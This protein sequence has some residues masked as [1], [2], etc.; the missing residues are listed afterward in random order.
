[1][2]KKLQA[3]YW[4]TP[5]NLKLLLKNQMV[6]PITIPIVIPG[7]KSAL[8]NL[9]AFR[10]HV[11]QWLALAKKYPPKEG[12]EVLFEKKNYRSLGEQIIP[13]RLVI[14]HFQALILLIGRENEINKLRAN[15]ASWVEL[16]SP[17]KS[18]VKPFIDVLVDNLDFVQHVDWVTVN[19]LA[20]LLSQIEKGMGKGEYL[21]KLPLKEVDTKFIEMHLN[22]IEQLSIVLIDEN[23][24]H[25]GLL[26]WLSVV[27]KPK[28]WLLVIPLCNNAR[29]LFGD[30]PLLRLPSDYLQ[31]EKLPV[32]RLIIVENEQSAL[33]L[34]P[35]KNTIAIAGAGKNTSWLD[36][37]FFK[38]Q[39]IGYWG[40][41]DSEG[42]TILSE[43]RKKQPH[44]QSL[45]M[46]KST[47]ERFKE[48]MV[49]EPLSIF[50]EP[51]HLTFE[52]LD[53][54]RQLRDGQF[55]QNRLEQERISN[56]FIE[57]FLNNWL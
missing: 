34:P 36:A 8:D 48:R 21:R 51:T 57:K 28:H 46:D 35:M 17:A 55:V 16:F 43:A 24:E 27:P 29:R 18:K 49:Q 4:E 6:F 30:L 10:E 23:I 44:I 47:V 13:R 56:D 20:K 3:K 39:K 38:D 52:E 25:I 40:D 33:C 50:K 41:I 19:L 26:E 32:D 2:I 12:I 45:M 11:T 54:F 15:F 53:L 9:D 31:R 22:F 5:V 7:A 1:M 42:L 37:H 14:S